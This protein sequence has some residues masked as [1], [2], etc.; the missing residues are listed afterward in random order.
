MLKTYTFS[1][2]LDELEARRAA[3][4]LH[5]SGLTAEGVIRLLLE[6]TAREG[7]L[8]IRKT[9]SRV[10]RQPAAAIPGLFVQGDLF[11]S[12]PPTGEAESFS[13]AARIPRLSL[14]TLASLQDAQA[15]LRWRARERGSGD[16]GLLSRSPA[17]RLELLE[18]KQFRIDKTL[19]ASA[20]ERPAIIAALEA[21]FTDLTE[22]RTPPGARPA[23]S[24]SAQY[25]PIHPAGMPEDALAVV[26][27]AGDAEICLARYG[28]PSD[29]LAEPPK[30]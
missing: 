19:I 14:V 8:P 24:G 30:N 20:P 25:L 4:V 13:E 27:E 1:I 18:T 15:I 9:R 11:S 7:A 29:I 6:R 10:Q 21:V 22:G 23:G 16:G 5:E 12:L 3:E 26:Y 28:S 17:G 2:T